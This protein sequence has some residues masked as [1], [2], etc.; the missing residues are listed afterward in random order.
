MYCADLLLNDL[1]DL[2]LEVRE[3]PLEMDFETNQC[4][5]AEYQVMLKRLM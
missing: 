3:A 2:D 4:C 1:D 5:R